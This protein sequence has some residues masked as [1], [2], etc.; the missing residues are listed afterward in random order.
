MNDFT[1]ADCMP[2]RPEERRDLNSRQAQEP[3]VEHRAPERVRRR[4]PIPHG[5]QRVAV[6]LLIVALI[7]APL[8]VLGFFL[9]LWWSSA[10]VPMSTN[11]PMQGTG[12]HGTLQSLDWWCAGR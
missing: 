6:T 1:L 10:Q 4:L 9:F 7:L 5:W 2:R 8:F 11:P 3:A 12:G